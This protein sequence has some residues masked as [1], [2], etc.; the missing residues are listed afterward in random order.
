MS[1]SPEGSLDPYAVRDL[2]R[3][4]QQ[5]REEAIAETET[6]TIEDE[7]ATG[8]YGDEFF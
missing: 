6:G 3:E 8:V 5:R 4:L 2:V 1:F 7:I